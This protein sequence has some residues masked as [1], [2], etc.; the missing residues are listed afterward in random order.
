MRKRRTNKQNPK[1]PTT[2]WTNPAP[3][4]QRQ[5]SKTQETTQHHNHNKGIN[6]IKK[7]TSNIIENDQSRKQAALAQ[8]RKNKAKQ[9]QC[10]LSSKSIIKM[11][12][13]K[14]EKNKS[15]EVINLV[16]DSSQSSPV[17]IYASNEPNAFMNTLSQSKEKKNKANP[18]DP[19]ESNRL[20]RRLN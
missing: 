2:N 15:I 16:P 17:K 10:K 14:L 11:D 9:R 8:L 5:Q 4:N 19:N 12:T 6:A 13:W 3:A 1:E 20:Q 7:V 18:N